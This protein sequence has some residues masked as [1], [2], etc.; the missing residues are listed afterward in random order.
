MRPAVYLS[1]GED[2][3][4][5]LSTTGPQD[6]PRR[7]RG[8]ADLFD[9]QADQIMTDL[10]QRA[11]AMLDQMAAPIQTAG[12]PTAPKAAPDSKRDSN[13]GPPLRVA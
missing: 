6:V 2:Q 8:R 3:E 5:G 10:K 13:D 1:V 12:Q 4:P 7:V 9:H 11:N